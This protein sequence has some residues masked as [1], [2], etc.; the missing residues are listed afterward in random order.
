M[1]NVLSKITDIL[2]YTYTNVLQRKKEKLYNITQ[3]THRGVTLFK[4]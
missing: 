3:L 2:T 4:I 1:R